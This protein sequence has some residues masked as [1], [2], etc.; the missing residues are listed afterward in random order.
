MAFYQATGGMWT[1]FQRIAY[2]QR[3]LSGETFSILAPYTG[4]Y[5]IATGLYAPNPGNMPTGVRKKRSAYIS[6]GA[7]YNNSGR[8]DISG[9]CIK[10]A[11]KGKVLYNGTASED[12]D[13]KPPCYC[14]YFLCAKELY[15]TNIT[16]LGCTSSGD[17]NPQSYT[18]RIV[19][20][21]DNDKEKWQL[22]GSETNVSELSGYLFNSIDIVDPNRE[23][24]ISVIGGYK[25]NGL[26]N[27]SVI[28]RRTLCT[29]ETAIIPPATTSE[30]NKSCY[31]YEYTDRQAAGLVV[32]FYKF[33]Q[34][35]EGLKVGIG[36]GEGMGHLLKVTI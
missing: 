30:D 29:G 34:P 35:V 19:W 1:P 9:Y 14:I 2:D 12:D 24:L 33:L 16:Y 10:Y 7:D 31:Y 23:F 27:N 4:T 21:P 25:I 13:T 22:A 8:V 36:S 11:E 5:L 15:G 3:I 6:T 26:T 20:D 18:H 32:G 17:Y 28:T